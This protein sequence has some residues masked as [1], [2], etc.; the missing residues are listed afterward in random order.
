MFDKKWGNLPLAMVLCLCACGTHGSTSQDEDPGADSLYTDTFQPDSAALEEE[1]LEQASPLAHVD[2]T[3]DDFLFAFA[4]S[5]TLQAQRVASPLYYTDD[6][7]QQV[8][9]EQTNWRQ[10]F[11]FLDA[12]FYTVLFGNEKQI[13]QVKEQ[14]LDSASV[15]RI[16]LQAM[17]VTDYTFHRMEQGWMLTAVRGRHFLDL[18]LSDFLT[19]YTRFSTDSIF[20][21]ESIAQ[22]LR[23]TML[24]P[25]DDL[26]YIQGTIDADQW[27]IFCPEVPSGVISNIRYGQTYGNHRHV[28]M[29]KCGA[30]NGMQEILNFSKEGSR[31]LL[32]SYEN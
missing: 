10:E 16:D 28:V 7:G 23:I 18:D 3:F 8:Q 29:Q 13:E 24:D 31:W 5:R 12:E 14:D 4:R 30:A 32:T 2:D 20:Q 6:Q 21:S 1:V 17:R 9:M 15:E 25:D 22:P 19:F 11:A 27:P 26:Q